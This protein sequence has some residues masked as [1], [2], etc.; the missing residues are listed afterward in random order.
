MKTS[1]SLKSLKIL[2]N[3]ETHYPRIE[4][5]SIDTCYLPFTPSQTLIDDLVAGLQENPDSDHN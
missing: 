1:S 4:D 5:I 2:K 3:L